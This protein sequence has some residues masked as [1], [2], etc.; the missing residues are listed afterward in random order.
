MVPLVCAL[1]LTALLLPQPSCYNNITYSMAGMVSLMSGAESGSSQS[2]TSGMMSPKGS[3]LSNRVFCGAD[4]TRWT[5][6]PLEDDAEGTIPT[7]I[8]PSSLNIPRTQL[9]SL[10]S[11]PIA[12]LLPPITY[13]IALLTVLAFG[14][15]SYSI[16]S[17]SRSEDS[18][19]GLARLVHSTFIAG[20]IMPAEI[21]A[22]T[23]TIALF[24]MVKQSCGDRSGL[25]S[26][27]ES[28]SITIVESETSRTL[29]RAVPALKM[30][31]VSYL[32]G[33][34]VIEITAVLESF[35]ILHTIGA[36]A[37]PARPAKFE[38][39]MTVE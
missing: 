17:E 9:T 22:M 6:T 1:S 18:E 38:T 16:A 23:S 14:T 24:V 39:T 32:K 31:S 4:A 8:A 5:R 35:A 33:I 10:F 20:F 13:T 25:L 28:L 15:A 36:I 37:V 21:E 12:T 29:L 27:N 26:K 11:S 34:I 30:R 19:L 2:S 7:S 3:Y